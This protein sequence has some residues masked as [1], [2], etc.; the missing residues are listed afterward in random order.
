MVLWVGPTRSCTTR[1]PSQPE[2]YRTNRPLTRLTFRSRLLQGDWCIESTDIA[3]V[4]GVVVTVLCFRD[5][6]CWLSASVGLFQCVECQIGAEGVGYPPA[7]DERRVH[8][9]RPGRHIGQVGHPQ[10]VRRHSLEPAVYQIRRP[11]TSVI[12]NGCA[13]FSASY[14]NPKSH[15]QLA[16]HPTQTGVPSEAQPGRARQNEARSPTAEK[17]K[18]ALP[19]PKAVSLSYRAFGEEPRTGEPTSVVVVAVSVRSS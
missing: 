16:S 2:H 3:R 9:S 6:R 19:M 7:D 15:V 18:R 17:G 11:R 14:H 5:W 10:T 13:M 4:Q 12:W 8:E 1:S